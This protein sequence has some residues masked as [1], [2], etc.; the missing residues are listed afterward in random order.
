MLTVRRV[1][2]LDGN[3]LDVELSNGHTLLL[4]FTGIFGLPD[5]SALR[6]PALFCEPKTDGRSVYWDGGA[7]I[8]MEKLFEL[9]SAD[10]LS[11]R[12]V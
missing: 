5:Y 9:L 1:G 7:K 8:T 12:E 3:T 10:S 2:V 11:A 6:D 4:D